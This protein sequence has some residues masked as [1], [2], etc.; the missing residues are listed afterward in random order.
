MKLLI[1]DDHDLF[2]D[3]LKSYF[4]KLKKDY[5]IDFAK[6]LPTAYKCIEK[7]K[8]PYDLVILDL[9]MPGMN[10]F[11]GLQKIKN[12]WPDQRTAIISGVAQAWEVGQS[13]ENGAAG[14]FPKSMSG[15][16]LIHAIELVCSGEKFVP[17]EYLAPP[18]HNPPPPGHPL[19]RADAPDHHYK[20][21]PRENDVLKYLI[22]GASNQVIADGLGLKVVTVKLHVRSIC[23]KL[24]ARNRTQ[25]AL[26][27]R[28]QNIVRS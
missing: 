13:I 12:Q 26:Y 22:R 8:S 25:A 14:F 10:G 24:G 23:R 17:I 21:T 20:L 6:D 15:K 4:E 16:S 9:C 19:G 3:I 7:Q 5:D 1:A 27:A 2:C 18:V 11:E 28:E